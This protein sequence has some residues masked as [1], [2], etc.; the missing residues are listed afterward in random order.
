MAAALPPTYRFVFD[1]EGG[2][3]FSGLVL[4]ARIAGAEKIVDASDLVEELNAGEVQVLGVE[5]KIGVL[6]WPFSSSGGAYRV[7]L[8]LKE[9]G[10]SAVSSSESSGT[11][12]A[13]ELDSVAS[14]ERSDVKGI[15]RGAAADRRSGVLLPGPP[16][17]C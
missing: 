14:T 9:S 13:R 7:E 1:G 12:V 2:G 4:T 6:V 11:D 16:L 5:K 8:R 17:L 3:D 10:A 15:R